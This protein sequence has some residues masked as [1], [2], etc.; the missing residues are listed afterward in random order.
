MA[1][2]YD[3]MLVVRVAGIDDYG[4]IHQ[5]ELSRLPGVTRLESSF[6][7]RDV[8]ESKSEPVSRSGYRTP[9]K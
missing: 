2:Q 8:L 4:R 3:Y 5:S 6:A 1:G 9:Q 7:L